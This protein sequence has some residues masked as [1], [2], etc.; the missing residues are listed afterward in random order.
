MFVLIFNCNGSDKLVTTLP[1]QPATD[2]I[3]IETTKQPTIQKSNSSFVPQS[4]TSNIS[5]MSHFTTTPLSKN[6]AIGWYLVY[7]L[8]YFI[9]STFH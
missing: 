8:F 7:I 5:F 3:R 2:V 9:L 4:P 6:S 1:N